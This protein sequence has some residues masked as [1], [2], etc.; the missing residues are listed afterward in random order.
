MALIEL[1]LQTGQA[2]K[3]LFVADRD[4]LVTQALE[5]GFKQHLPEEPRDLIFTKH[6]DKT[7]R[8]Y[9]S[10]QQTLERCY[11]DF[12]PGFFDLVI[13][14]EAHRSLFNKF[15]EVVDYFDAR[16]IG[17]TATPASFINQNTFQLFHC[18]GVTPTF[19]YPYRQAVEEKYLVN[20]SLYRAQT[21][22]QRQ[23]ISGVDL[24]EYER[25]ALIEQGKD[26]DDIDF[27]GSDLEKKVT[28]KDTLRKQWEEIIEVC[29][30]DESGSCQ[31]K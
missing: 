10:T 2:L 21:R 9:V 3:V 13:F 7:K 1:F 15:A 30:K 24:S 17:L 8:L 18:E 22:F 4:A 25:N 6:I 27:S 31:Q 14:D 16:M 19:L 20:F 5:K 29:F 11:Q 26:P 28:N 23:G 12:S